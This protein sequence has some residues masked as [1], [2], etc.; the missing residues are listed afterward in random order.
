M[1]KPRRVWIFSSH[2]TNWWILS[3][4]MFNAFFPS[5]LYFKNVLDCELRKLGLSK[6]LL[7]D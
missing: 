3:C 5:G 1:I 2:G 6:W 7:G 4:R